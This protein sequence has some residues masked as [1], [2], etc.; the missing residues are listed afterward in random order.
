ML[1]FVGPLVVGVAVMTTGYLS[2]SIPY[3]LIAGFVAT[4]IVAIGG[5][6]AR[7]RAASEATSADLPVF[8]P[9]HLP[10]FEADREQLGS[11]IDGDEIIPPTPN[12]G[13]KGH[14]Y[15][16]PRYFGD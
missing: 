13:Q 1:K 6:I 4:G 10:R 12:M 3:A 9:G 16:G 2:G 8:I 11:V 5:Y 14:P 7:R 15:R